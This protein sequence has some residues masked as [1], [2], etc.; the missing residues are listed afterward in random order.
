MRTTFTVV[1]HYLHSNGERKDLELISHYPIDE[2]SLLLFIIAAMHFEYAA[3]TLLQGTWECKQLACLEY[4]FLFISL[5][6]NFLQKRFASP[7]AYK[8]L[9][10]LNEI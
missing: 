1:W 5:F 6:L 3:C 2:H 8:Q 9:Q 4:S 10:N 7:S